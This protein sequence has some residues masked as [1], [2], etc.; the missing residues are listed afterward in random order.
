MFTPT[1]APT[2]FT[3][4]PTA[5]PTATPTPSPTPT[6]TPTPTS[7]HYPITAPI[8]APSCTPTP[9]PAHTPVRT[10]AI[11]LF[12]PPCSCSPLLPQTSGQTCR[13]DPTW[14]QTVTV[15]LQT[16]LYLHCHQVGVAWV[17][18]GLVFLCCGFLW[19]DL[20]DFMVLWAP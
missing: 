17:W 8:P 16:I 12:H 14:Q 11:L 5:T 3:S 20:F 19:L 2:T 15:S 9:V 4:S 18:F 7:V 6:P 1:L 10:P 13:P